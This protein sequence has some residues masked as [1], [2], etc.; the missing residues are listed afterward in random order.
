MN[1]LTSLRR[2]FLEM[3]RLMQLGLVI[4]VVGG[5]LDI[6]FHASPSA[7]T[8]SIEA[9]LGPDGYY[10]HLVTLAG[11]VTTLVGLFA[12]QI[13]RIRRGSAGD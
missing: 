4:L 3:P 8:P 11:M 2:E 6:L 5:A 7:W 12:G 13:G 10:A 9:Y 1:T